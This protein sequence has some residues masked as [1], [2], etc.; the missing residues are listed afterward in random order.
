MDRGA[1]LLAQLVAQKAHQMQHGVDVGARRDALGHGR[2]KGVDIVVGDV[3]QRSLL[4]VGEQR[5][6]APIGGLAMGQK[7]EF[8]AAVEVDQSLG[9]QAALA[10]VQPAPVVVDEH[11]LD[12]VLA[13]TVVVETALLFHRHQRETVHQ[14]RREQA[15]GITP[16]HLA[17]LAVNANALHAA[18]RRLGHQHEAAQIPQPLHGVGD[19]AVHQGGK[20]PVAAGRLETHAVVGIHQVHGRPRRGQAGA[21]FRA[22]GAEPE[23][24]RQHPGAIAGML[25]AAVVAHLA[26]H[27]AG[28]DAHRNPL[29]VAV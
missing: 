6:Q 20:I 15:A 27:Q 28:T 29:I 26:A 10:L 14:C 1:V 25:M 23:I 5:P 16:G 22:Q 24:A 4:K 8:M 18:A 11:T 7:L 9:G 12:E 13:Q 17:V 21:H 2:H 19:E 3:R